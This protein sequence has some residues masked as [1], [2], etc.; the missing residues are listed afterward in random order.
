MGAASPEEPQ[1]VPGG[2]SWQPE[3]LED[4]I[5]PLKVPA[6]HGNATPACVP[7][8]KQWIIST[9]GAGRNITEQC[10]STVVILM[11]SL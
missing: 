11:V 1:Y 4:P 9:D 3:S 5:C 8:D 7:A 6:G 2:Q 10:V